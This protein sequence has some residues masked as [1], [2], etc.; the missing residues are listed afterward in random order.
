MDP[1]YFTSSLWEQTCAQ[2][3]AIGGLRAISIPQVRK[4]GRPF[5]IPEQN[6]TKPKID[7][8]F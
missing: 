1:I 4:G 8:L 7:W 5:V 3:K 6:L 2:E